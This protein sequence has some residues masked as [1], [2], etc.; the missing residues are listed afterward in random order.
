MNYQAAKEKARQEA[1]EYQLAYSDHNYSY[2]ELAE[3]N[4]ILRQS[5]NAM[6]FSPNSG[7]TALYK[8]A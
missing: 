6:D 8:E 7:R 4:T 3:S 2:A 5:E 1:M